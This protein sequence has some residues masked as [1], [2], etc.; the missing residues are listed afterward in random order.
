MGNYHPFTLISLS[1]D[2]QSD[3]YNPLPYHRTNLILH[4]LNSC[5]VFLLIYRLIGNSY[6]A[7]LLLYYLEFIRYMQNLWRGL[8]KER[9]CCSLSSSL[10]LYG[11]MQDSLKKRIM[12]LRTCS[13]L[14]YFQPVVKGNGSFTCTNSGFGRLLL[15]EEYKIHKSCFREN[16]IFSAG[17]VFRNGGCL[18]SKFGA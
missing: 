15:W 14:L 7:F 6:T 8:P 5:L 13:G 4:I 3:K 17:F 18:C 2:Y 9:M 12:F 16:S 1:L 11:F 10:F